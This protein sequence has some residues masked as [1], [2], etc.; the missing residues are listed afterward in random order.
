[1]CGGS[2]SRMAKSATDFA[3]RCGSCRGESHSCGHRSCPSRRRLPRRRNREHRWPKQGRRWLVDPLCGTL[4]Y[5]ARTPPVA[6][7]VALSIDGSTTAAVSAG[8]IAGELFWTDGPNAWL[9]HGGTDAVLAPSPKSTA[10]LVVGQTAAA[11][12][13]SG[14]AA[15]KVSR[16]RRELWRPRS[17][18]RGTG[19]C[20]CPSAHR[21]G[22]PLG[23]SS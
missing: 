23:Q 19:R 8:P 10:M 13:A 20:A 15:D 9:R 11:V 17:L 12:L 14:P 16:T 2:L 4:N 1:M 22:R 6:V 7:N 21:S 5:A 18:G 3:N